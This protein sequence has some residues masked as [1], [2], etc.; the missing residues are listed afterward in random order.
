MSGIFLSPFKTS[1][2]QNNEENSTRY[3]PLQLQKRLPGLT[4]SFRGFHL[5]FLSGFYTFRE[6]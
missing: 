6:N 2:R 5:F 3:T 4:A 1:R